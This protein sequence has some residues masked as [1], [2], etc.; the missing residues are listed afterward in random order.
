M[1]ALGPGAPG[2]ERHEE[3]GDGLVLGLA[4]DRVPRRHVERNGDASRRVGGRVRDVR[5][6]RLARE[7]ERRAGGVQRPVRHE[8]DVLA[9]PVRD[10]RGLERGRARKGA[11]ARGAREEEAGDAR[12]EDGRDLQERGLG[13]ARR[14]RDAR[15]SLRRVSAASAA[16]V[17][18]TKAGAHGEVG[19]VV[20]PEA[21][22]DGLHLGGHRR[23]RG[24]AGEMRRERGGAVPGALARQAG[25]DE[26]TDLQ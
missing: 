22:P 8:G 11:A 19:A 16:V 9:A 7:V 18:A 10:G 3:V 12:H 6:A 20:V 13:A 14:E 17:R 25:E 4:D 21:G 1:R 5:E 2:H 15:S 24:A 23:A 26:F